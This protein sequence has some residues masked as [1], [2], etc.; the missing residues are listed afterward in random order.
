MIEDNFEIDKKNSVNKAELYDSNQFGY[1]SVHYIIQLNDIRKK[2]PEWLTFSNL[3]AEIQV[4]TVLQHSWASISHELSYK[5]GYEIPKELERKLFR[6]A[7]L[8]ELADEQF[9]KIR[10]EHITLNS[11]IKKLT[12]SN[13][14][15]QLEINKLTLKYSIEKPESIYQKIINSAYKIGFEEYDESDE[16]EEHNYKKF[17]YSEIIIVTKVLNFKHL[18]EL[19]EGLK[20]NKK[21][22]NEVL[23]SIIEKNSPWEAGSTFLTLIASMVLLNEKQLDSFSQKS[24]WDNE[25]FELIANSIIDKK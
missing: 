23:I 18:N 3:K 1:L 15:K 2:L 11:S 17:Y 14:P 19:E 21:L 13:K 22:I 9:L 8:F 16:I 4:R 7:G 12:K 5:K 20:I 10:D 24:D 25:I 6:L